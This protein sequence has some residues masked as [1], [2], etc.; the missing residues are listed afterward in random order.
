MGQSAPRAPRRPPERQLRDAFLTRLSDELSSLRPRIEQSLAEPAEAAER[1]L[2]ASKLRNLAADAS[3]MRQVQLAEELS[4]VR[5]VIQS[6]GVLVA[7]DDGDRRHLDDAFTRISAYIDAEQARDVTDNPIARGAHPRAS[8][9]VLRVLMVGAGAAAE[10]LLSEDWAAEDEAPALVVEQSP[11]AAQARHDVKHKKP[12]VIII[13]SD[14]GGARVLVD[15][16]VSDDDTEEIPIIVL[17][18]WDCA[19]D[20]AGYIALGVARTL[21]KPV[22]PGALRR[23]CLTVAPRKPGVF[24]PLGEITLD[25]L[26]ARL[27]DELH[28]GLCDAA[29]DRLRRKPVQF[30]T[31]GEVLTVLWEAVARIR[32]L[33]TAESA[34][35][36]KF[37]NSAVIEA[38]PSAG[39]MTGTSRRPHADRSSAINEVR[40]GG[41][42]L[43]LDGIRV[44]GRG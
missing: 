25:A 17:G 13:D 14:L 1:E 40:E 19:E 18:K 3:R 21:A 24:E 7:L 41:A 39:W 35:M 34:G 23:A 33:V 31:G 15:R 4:V 37:Q 5:A 27:S 28:R 32:E 43:P 30:G 6:V 22:S 44:C 38:L 9:G 26:G 20:A 2:L 11:D 42:V 29:D 36:L 10:S 8:A 16:L 12:Q